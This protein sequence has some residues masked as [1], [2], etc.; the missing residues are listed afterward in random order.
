V[1]PVRHDHG[2]WWVGPGAES[3]QPDSLPPDR[4]SVQTSAR[5]RGRRSVRGDAEPEGTD[6]FSTRGAAGAPYMRLS[7]RT[8]AARPTAPS[9]S[10]TDRDSTRPP[11]T[12]ARPR[13]R[14]AQTLLA[15]SARSV[16]TASGVNVRTWHNLAALATGQPVRLLGQCGLLDVLHVSAVQLVLRLPRFGGRFVSLQST[17]WSWRPACRLRRLS[18]SG[19][20]GPNATAPDYTNPRCS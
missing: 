6:R 3:L 9:N 10:N 18:V 20:P 15:A 14:F 12:A 7:I 8:S 2:I 5:D 17:S 11:P 4:A 19:I 16:C 1:G 13:K